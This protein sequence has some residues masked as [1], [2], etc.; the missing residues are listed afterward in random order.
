MS[1]GNKYWTEFPSNRHQ[2]FKIMFGDFEKQLRIPRK[3]VR[4]FKGKWSD[5]VHLRGPSKQLWTVKLTRTV[6]DLFLHN[7][8]EIFVE[9]HGL[10]ETDFL[11]FHYDDNSTF[12][13]IIFNH[14]GCERE[15]SYFS[16]K[17]ASAFSPKKEPDDKE[18][19]IDLDK[20]QE[21]DKQKGKLKRKMGNQSSIASS[22]GAR[23]EFH[24]SG[25][26]K[27]QKMFGNDFEEQEKCRDPI[28][29]EEVIDFRKILEKH[30]QKDKQKGKLKR[31]GGNQSLLAS[32]S[33]SSSRNEVHKPAGKEVNEKK[34]KLGTDE[35][36]GG[37]SVK[38]PR[39]S[40][41]KEHVKPEKQE[42]SSGELFLKHVNCKYQVLLPGKFAKKTGLQWKKDTTIKDPEGRAFP[43][44]I[45]VVG[46]GQ[47]AYLSSGWKNL[48]SANG[49]QVGST[50]SFKYS[51]GKRNE[52]E[53]E[54]LSTGAATNEEKAKDP[55][56][57]T[58]VII[59]D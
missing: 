9:D 11:V 34:K 41:R 52:I 37:S 17:Q 5:T 8:W 32:G 1:A 53:L 7:G 43:V 44:G 45:T 46:E 29:A 19:V 16:Q 30:T 35:C 36:E 54:I 33:G 3:F 56:K 38:R 2:F 31:K 55:E 40:L 59:I 50:I 57:K 6:D 58:S 51:H 14:T 39:T 49:L 12:N 28:V 27:K 15:S 21:K 26:K 48:W 13:V 23:K 25:Q 22:S 18:D 47:Q 42:S 4:N 24:Q 10:E 20:V